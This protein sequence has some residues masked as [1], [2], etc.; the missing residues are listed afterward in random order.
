MTLQELLSLN[1]ET[2]INQY[3]TF[4]NP[5]TFGI[6]IDKGYQKPGTIDIVTWEATI[7]YFKKRR[8]QEDFDRYF[9]QQIR[10]NFPYYRER[11]RV[12]PTVTQIDWFA[13]IYREHHS[14][15]QTR[16]IDSILE[17]VNSEATNIGSGRSQ[18]DGTSS[19]TSN[20]TGTE[21]NTD[22][23]INESDQ[24]QITQQRNAPANASYNWSDTNDYANHQMS[25]GNVTKTSGA[26]AGIA[27]PHITNPSATQDNYGM[28][29][30]ISQNTHSGSDTRSNTNSN[31]DQNITQSS[32]SNT[33][34]AE[35]TTER[36]GQNDSD[37]VSSEITT[38]RNNKLSE[39]IM[40]ARACIE[41]TT[42][43]E[44]FMNKLDPAFMQAW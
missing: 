13:E 15:V 35:G 34:T 37:A 38:G 42:S 26:G 25:A 5:L 44:F 7:D 22:A 4:D 30:N 17:T 41:G 43:F 32:S 9:K 16:N 36:H 3:Y 31:T 18:T 1:Q 19:G 40:D 20:S 14:E 8:I 27:N 2:L 21:S 28:G 6:L 12:D 39:M 23:A 29:N 11:L 24:R 33:S 10:I